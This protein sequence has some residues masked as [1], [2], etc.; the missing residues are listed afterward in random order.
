[1]EDLRSSY[2][3]LP[4]NGDMSFQFLPNLISGFNASANDVANDKVFTNI[5]YL[6][7]PIPEIEN[8]YVNTINPS[9]SESNPLA[10]PAFIENAD[11]RNETIFQCP[12]CEISFKEYNEYTDHMKTHSKEISFQ[13]TKCRKD[14][15]KLSLYQKHS[16]IHQEEKL[17]NCEVCHIGFNIENNYKVH[18]ALHGN[19][20]TCPICDLSFQRMAS[21][22]S[23]LAIHQVEE[24]HT[25]P[26][27]SS[28]FENLAD[29]KKHMKTHAQPI[30]TRPK[31]LICSYCKVKFDSAA[32]LRQHISSHVKVK[33]LVLNGKKYKKNQNINVEYKHQCTVCSKT[34]PKLSL[35]ERHIRIHSGER[36]LCVEFAIRAS[37][38]KELFKYIC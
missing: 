25:C 14:F 21:L 28:E 32:L 15:N 4:L 11:V 7:S 29:L 27:C 35:L 20:S 33:K 37:H 22:K 31:E 13:C 34:F 2:I 5:E 36:P 6:I 17:F 10:E 26:E 9:V 8:V 3:I 24:F 38:K 1:M 30:G 23:H 18:M 16:L 12:K 19:A